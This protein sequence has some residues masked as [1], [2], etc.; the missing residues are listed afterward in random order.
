MKTINQFLAVTFVLSL[1]ALPSIPAFAETGKVGTV[2]E[3][4]LADFQKMRAGQKAFVAQS[5]Y[6]WYQYRLNNPDTTKAFGPEAYI[7]PAYGL[8]SWLVGAD[9]K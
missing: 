7:N 3:L 1:A 5:Q 4:T 6:E 2:G 8:K 9:K